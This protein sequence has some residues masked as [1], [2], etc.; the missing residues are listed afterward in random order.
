MHI[1]QGSSHRRQHSSTGVQSR[2][3]AVYDILTTSHHQF[4]DRAQ[5]EVRGGKG[6]NGCISHEILRY[7]IAPKSAVPRLV[8]NLSLPNLVPEESDPAV[9]RV[10]KE[11]MCS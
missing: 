5:I 4:A 1:L 3:K 10:A 6:G 7:G 9:D 11:E 8:T 2:L